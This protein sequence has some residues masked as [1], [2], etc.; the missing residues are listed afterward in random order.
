MADEKQEKIDTS[1]KFFWNEEDVF[2][3]NE[4]EVKQEEE[5]KKTKS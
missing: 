3:S 5:N 1:D 2:F 4:E